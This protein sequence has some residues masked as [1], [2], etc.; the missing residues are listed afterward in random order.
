MLITTPF[1]GSSLESSCVA[2]SL[3]SGSPRREPV[4]LS[5]AVCMEMYYWHSFLVHSFF[6]NQSQPTKDGWHT[7]VCQLWAWMPLTW[8]WANSYSTMT[9]TMQKYKDS[10]DVLVW[11]FNMNIQFCPGVKPKDEGRVVSTWTEQFCPL[12]WK[13]EKE[14]VWHTD[15]PLLLASATS[16]FG[17]LV[18]ADWMNRLV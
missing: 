11:T 4:S 12:E 18:G 1:L 6:S 14:I 15:C 3:L 9:I 7:A 10:P 8:Q 13:L 17:G 5:S 16:Y 2:D